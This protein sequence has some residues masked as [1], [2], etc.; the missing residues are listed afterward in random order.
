[1]YV[2][3]YV[4]T[5]VRRLAFVRETTTKWHDL[6]QKNNTRHRKQHSS[7]WYNTRQM[8]NTFQGENSPK[9]VNT[10]H[11]RNVLHRAQ[12]LSLEQPS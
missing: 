8:V 6:R 1:M 3:M 9:K 7:Q 11:R 12:Y 10:G 5:L 2:C 4:T